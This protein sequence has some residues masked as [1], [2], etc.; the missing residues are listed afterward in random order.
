LDKAI[1]FFLL[2][3]FY[4]ANYLIL[5]KFSLPRV[6]MYLIGLKIFVAL[7]MGHYDIYRFIS[8]VQYFIAN[9]AVNPWLMSS[10]FSYMDFPY[11]PAFLYLLSII[12]LPFINYLDLSSYEPNLLTYALIRIP[13]LGADLLLLYFLAKERLL[14]ERTSQVFYF[15]SPVIIFHQYYS[16]QFDILPAVLFFIAFLRLSKCAHLDL[17]SGLLIFMS[18]AIKPFLYLLLPFLVAHLGNKN[19]K[20]LLVQASKLLVI[21]IIAKLAELPYLLDAI[22]RSE[23][24]VGP[25]RFLNNGAFLIFYFL[26]LY[27]SL[28]KTWEVDLSKGIVL[29]ILFVAAFV[30]SHSAGWMFWIIPF[31]LFSW[32]NFDK[33]IAAF[34]WL[35]SFFF[36]IRWGV[37]DGSPLV[38]SFDVFVSN[39]LELNQKLGIGYFYQVFMTNWGI[40]TAESIVRVTKKLFQATSLILII[41]IA[42][43]A[44]KKPNH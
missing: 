24:G 43:E 23:L 36:V 14:T 6:Y 28:S 30:S 32:K 15:L 26:L 4:V 8:F 3:F 10:L 44:I 12:F 5:K 2:M 37:V 31:A 20:L 34:F 39:W 33:K 16:G 38:D 17:V 19:F 22:Y 13:L 27:F 29:I 1:V 41:M 40:E 21:A 35:W 42:K 9:P 18:L 25:D 7:T 11:P